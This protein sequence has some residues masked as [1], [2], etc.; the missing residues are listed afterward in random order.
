MAVLVESWDMQRIRSATAVLMIAAVVGCESSKPPRPPAP[1][2]TP[3]TVFADIIDSVKASLEDPKDS[4][5]VLFRD[6]SGSRASF[7]YKVDGRYFAPKDS[8][9]SH[10]GIIQVE[11]STYYASGRKS[12]P[13]ADEEKPNPREESQIEPIEGVDPELLADLPAAP[14]PAR[15]FVETTPRSHETDDATDYEFEWIDDRWQLVSDVAFEGHSAVELAF[16]TALK[17]Q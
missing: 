10:R 2:R 5:I 7:R 1:P 13:A 4:R 3:E 16:Q 14:P 17:R 11:H 15:L 9:G 6:G 8:T 12:G